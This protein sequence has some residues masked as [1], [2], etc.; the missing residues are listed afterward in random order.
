VIYVVK[1]DPL[2]Y[3]V[4]RRFN[5]FAWLREALV[6]RYSGLFIP[7]LPS[8]TR[9]RGATQ[10]LTGEKTDIQGDF[11]KNRM[12]QLNMFAHQLCRIPFVRTDP[13]F[14][15]FVSISND[16]E[17]KNITDNPQNIEKHTSFENWKNDGLD[18]WF[19]ILDEYIVN[20]VDSD[21]SIMEFRRQLDMIIKILE[22]IEKEAKITGTKAVHFVLS[23]NQL[24]E[25]FLTWQKL[26]NDLLGPGANEVVS[27]HGPRVK[28][29]MTNLL[30]GQL[31]WTSNMA[32]RII[33]LASML[34]LEEDLTCSMLSMFHHR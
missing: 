11:V 27:P 30:L 12:A 6:H 9:L 5:D 3:S 20:Q 1:T 21:R 23:S 7:A 4:K 34:S 18:I 2:G 8:T 28:Q 25:Q 15:A 29:L 31:Q 10:R 24:Q 17:W 22:L 13:A 19:N 32:V 33:T 16:K 14:I 26:E